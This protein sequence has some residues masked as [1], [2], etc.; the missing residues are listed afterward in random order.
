MTNILSYRFSTRYI[1]HVTLRHQLRNSLGSVFWPQNHILFSRLWT[2]CSLWTCSNS[3]MPYRIQF[4][5]N[6]KFLLQPLSGPAFLLFFLSPT[7]W[8]HRLNGHE[9]GW[10]PGVSDGQGGLVCCGSWGRKESDTTEW[11]SWTEFCNNKFQM[12][13]NNGLKTRERGFCEERWKMLGF[14]HLW[15]NC[16]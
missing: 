6:Y 15:I 7:G 14:R 8:H 4:I 9:F 2:N 11:L 16:S 3:L 10:T 5:N 13:S 1:K 12:Q